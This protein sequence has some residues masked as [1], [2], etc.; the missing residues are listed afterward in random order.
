MQNRKYALSDG[1]YILKRR[2]KCNNTFR[3]FAN[4]HRSELSKSFIYRFSELVKR[5]LV[6]YSCR[7]DLRVLL[8][9]LKCFLSLWPKYPVYSSRSDV[10][11]HIEQFLLELLNLVAFCTLLTLSPECTQGIIISRNRLREL[12]DNRLSLLIAERFLDS[13][14]QSL[15]AVRYFHQIVSSCFWKYLSPSVFNGVQK[16]VEGLE[17]RIYALKHRCTPTNIFPRLEQFISRF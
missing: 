15:Y 11:A 17:H 1:P 6:E 8:K 12:I 13:I 7:F 10:I 3:C 4:Y 5:L 14:T 16:I 2:R 9:L